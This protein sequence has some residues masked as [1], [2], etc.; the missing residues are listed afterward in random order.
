MSLS[1]RMNNRLT[2]ASEMLQK[3]LDESRTRI[4]RELDADKKSEESTE[5]REFAP[6]IDQNKSQILP[7][8][9]LEQSKS[10][11]KQANALE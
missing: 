7:A 3:K 6:I 4:R 5:R 11:P 1:N 2:R 8:V 10:Q 9:V